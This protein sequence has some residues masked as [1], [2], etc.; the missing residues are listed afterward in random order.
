MEPVKGIKLGFSLADY[1]AKT[2]KKY[3][4][5][6]MKDKS[7]VKILTGDNSVDFFQVKNGR[8]LSAAGHHGEE[9]DISFVSKTL[10]RIQQFAE[11]GFD[12]IE[13]WDESLMK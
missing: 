8:L 9:Q 6:P 7:S 5:I 11:D 13:A 4:S 2:G 1:A 3:A 12:A 10:A